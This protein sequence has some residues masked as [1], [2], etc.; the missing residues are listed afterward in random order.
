MGPINQHVRKDVHSLGR[1]KK[2]RDSDTNK[3]AKDKTN[4]YVNRLLFIVGGTDLGYFR[5]LSGKSRNP[6][7]HSFEVPAQGDEVPRDGRELFLL[8]LH[9]FWSPPSDLLLYPSSRYLYRFS[10]LSFTGDSLSRV[11]FLSPR[12][13]R[14]VYRHS[15]GKTVLSPLRLLN[16]HLGSRSCMFD[17]LESVQRLEVRRQ[18]SGYFVLTIIVGDESH[19]RLYRS[20]VT[21][22]YVIRL[23]SLRVKSLLFIKSPHI[24]VLRSGGTL[25]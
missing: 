20:S 16:R 4:L 6:L 23:L 3:Q 19:Q 5:Y 12:T 10:L 17:T 9:P 22:I 2:C 13:P 15:H 21:F 8:L 25:F 1:P 7:Y 11:S 14:T 18:R 24:P